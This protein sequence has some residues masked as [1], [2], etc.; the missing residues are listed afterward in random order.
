LLP[1]EAHVYMLIIFSCTS[2]KEDCKSSPGM[3]ESNLVKTK[4]ARITLGIGFSN[5]NSVRIVNCI[6]K[7]FWK[8]GSDD[9]DYSSINLFGYID[10][11]EYENIFWSYLKSI[12]L[13]PGHLMMTKQILK[14]GK[15]YF[16][17]KN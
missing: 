14:I 10:D 1:K 5:L 2:F 15:I 6:L 12:R 8:T 3:H 11:M 7:V 16:S 13:G 4:E 17:F 9:I